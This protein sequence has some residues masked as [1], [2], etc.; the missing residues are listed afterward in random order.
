[1]VVTGDLTQVDLPSG[2]RS[3]LKD[4]LET[5]SHVKGVKIVN[6]KET[7]VVRNAMVTRMVQAYRR[8]EKKRNNKM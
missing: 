5:L 8:I 2:I 6:F 4:A 3:G 7:D 1:M